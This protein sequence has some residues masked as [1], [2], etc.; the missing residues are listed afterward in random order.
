MKLRISSR[1]GYRSGSARPSSIDVEWVGRD[2]HPSSYGLLG[3]NQAPA[4]RVDVY[5]G[6]AIF[7]DALVAGMDEVR[8]GLPDEYKEAVW[9]TL[10]VQPTLVAISRAAHAAAGS[11]PHVFRALTAMLCRLLAGDGSPDDAGLWSLWDR[12]WNDV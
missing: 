5:S 10:Q 1:L 4:A 8:W 2:G 9:E 6:N 3:G 12:C 7:T 11:S